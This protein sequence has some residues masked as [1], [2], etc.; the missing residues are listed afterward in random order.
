MKVKILGAH[1]C[2]TLEFRHTCFSVDDILAV[3]AGSIT[4]S[5][6]ME[7]QK[8]LAA[9]LLSHQHY[10]HI[11]DI[12]AIGTNLFHAGMSTDIFTIQQVSDI[13]NDHFFTSGI[14]R[15]LAAVPEHNP[16]LRINVIAPGVPF[17]AGQY[18]IIPI[19]VNH[20]AY[21][22]GFSITDNDGCE[23]FYTADTGPGLSECWKK[24][25]P[26]LLII[27]VTEPNR[28][29]EI[30]RKARHL[31]PELLEKE[32]ISFQ[33][34]KGYIPDIVTVHMSPEMEKDI[35]KELIAV[36]H[37]LGC[38]ILPGFEGMTISLQE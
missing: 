27:E 35:V 12:V 10:D 24:T 18:R 31:T 21:T 17:Q 11:R 6:S 9:V 34:I 23:I 8:K 2:E 7:E 13:L 26:K 22:T 1:N 29:T 32:L 38:S 36:S 20:S 28:S 16:S 15:N 14:Y 30:L 25:A 5:L 4:A 19:P 37:K 3:D 33:R